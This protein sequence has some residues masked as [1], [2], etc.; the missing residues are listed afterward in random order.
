M[1]FAWLFTEPSEQLPSNGLFPAYSVVA[2]I[3]NDRS[4]QLVT[5]FNSS[6]RYKS[7]R[8]GTAQFFDKKLKIEYNGRPIWFWR[9]THW[10][11]CGNCMICCHFLLLPLRLPP[12]PKKT[13]NAF[14]TKWRPLQHE[15]IPAIYRIMNANIHL[16]LPQVGSLQ[17]EKSKL[18]SFIQLCAFTT[19]RNIRCK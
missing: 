17:R 8:T 7:R 11:M 16:N 18:C 10:V 15:D 14:K 19:P 4:W 6:L 3:W 2:C 12:P 1:T 13:N 9:L 5:N